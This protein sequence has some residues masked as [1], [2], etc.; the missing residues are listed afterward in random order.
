MCKLEYSFLS[1]A[2]AILNLVKYVGSK[3]DDGTMT[4][5]TYTCLPKPE[6]NKEVARENSELEYQEHI[7]RPAPSPFA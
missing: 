1:A 5:N 3:V 6:R 7:T 2:Q 4:T